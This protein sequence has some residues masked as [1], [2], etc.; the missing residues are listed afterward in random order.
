MQFQPIVN[1]TSQIVDGYEALV[2]WQHP[3][4]G[5]IAPMDFIALAEDTG[6]IVDIGNW[7]IEQACIAAASWTEPYRVA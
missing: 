1:C 6:S 5:L 4:R 3:R 7:V 2:R